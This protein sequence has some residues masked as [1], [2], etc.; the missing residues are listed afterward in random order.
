M[1]R[2]VIVAGVAEQPQLGVEQV[3]G[4]GPV[5]LVD[6][7]FEEGHEVGSLSRDSDLAGLTEHIDTV[8]AGPDGFEGGDGIRGAT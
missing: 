7:R 1:L 4:T 5:N 2:R 8:G 3:A 6:H